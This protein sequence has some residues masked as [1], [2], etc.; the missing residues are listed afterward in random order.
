M[1][2]I[3]ILNLLALLCLIAEFSPLSNLLSEYS[4]Q[5]SFKQITDHVLESLT[6][7]VMPILL[8]LACLLSLI[9]LRIFS[10]LKLMLSIG[11][12]GVLAFSVYQ[13]NA[14][15]N[16]QKALLVF[17]ESND[18]FLL[19]NTYLADRYLDASESNAIERYELYIDNHQDGEH[20]IAAEDALLELYFDKSRYDKASY[21]LLARVQNRVNANGEDLSLEYLTYLASHYYDGDGVEQDQV[22]AVELYRQAADTG[23]ARAQSALGAAYSFGEG[24]EQ[25][26]AQSFLWFSK[27]AEQGY[28]V[29][30]YNLGVSYQRGLGV[31]Q[32]LDTAKK[33]FEKSAAQSYSIAQY[34]VGYMYGNGIGY[35]EDQSKKFEWY[36][37]AAEN[38]YVKGQ[39]GVAYS[40][41]K[42]L[43]VPQDFEQAYR[44]YKKAA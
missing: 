42:G 9:S 19:A 30:E 25:D 38:D 7:I 36:L 3:G 10:S 37:K 18:A 4:V 11:F 14:V 12:L 34:K 27:A 24:V 40:Y 26:H 23:F 13:S 29:A 31:E 5:F 41:A 28:D 2:T 8:L 44:W 21:K 39:F 1:R 33:W 16:E 17:A 15:T 43:G 35:E 32:N 20:T 22:K 6:L